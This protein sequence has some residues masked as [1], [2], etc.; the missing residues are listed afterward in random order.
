MLSWHITVFGG[1][2]ATAPPARPPACSRTPRASSQ[3]PR[4]VCRS[5]RLGHPR[6]PPETQDGHGRGRHRLAA[7]AGPGARLP[8]LAAVGGQGILGRQGR[9]ALETKP[10][11]LFKRQIWATF[12]EDYAAMALIPFFGDGH[13]LWASDYPHPDSVWPNS[14]AAIERQMGD[15]SPE[16]RSK[17]THDNAA[18]L[19]G[20]RDRRGPRSSSSTADRPFAM[21]GPAFNAGRWH[22]NPPQNGSRKNCHFKRS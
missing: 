20:L 16:M 8:P 7:L 11:E 17:L 21:S 10:R 18:R 4:T 3:L 19:Y 6:T 22:L 15:L 12:Q 14:R 1:R 9:R 5:V 2:P 13:L